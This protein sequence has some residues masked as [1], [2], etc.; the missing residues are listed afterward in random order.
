MAHKLYFDNVSTSTATLNDGLLIEGLT[1][2][3]PNDTYSF[4]NAGTITN[5]DRAV[6]RDTNNAITSWGS[7]SGEQGNDRNDALEFNFGSSKEIDFVALYFNAAETDSIRISHHNSASGD[8]TSFSN[9]TEDF[10]EK[11]NVRSFTKTSNQY[12]YVEATSGALAGVTEI[13][14]GT[15]FILPIDGNSITVSK[16]FNSFITSSY[17]NV[18]YSNKIDTEKLVWKIQLPII[19][20]ADK[21]N[22]E[23]LQSHYSNIYSFVY[24]DESEYHTVRLANPLQFNQIAIN[25]Y[26]TTL[27]LREE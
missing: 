2:N 8:V 12:W 21:T 9:L 27:T 19:T 13:F 15:E 24:Y 25:T 22:L 18:E 3:T 23:L 17:N 6:D 10:V 11:W 5:E 16:P 1:L 20:E 26:S 4:T 14:F 7:D